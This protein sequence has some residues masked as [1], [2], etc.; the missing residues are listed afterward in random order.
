MVKSSRMKGD[1]GRSEG[2][3]RRVGKRRVKSGGKTG[4]EWHSEW[5]EMVRELEAVECG[6]ED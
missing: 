1:G 2:R 6:A 5:R 4:E 3:E